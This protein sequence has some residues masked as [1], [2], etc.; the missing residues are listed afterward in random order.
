MNRA[1]IHAIEQDSS[2][3]CGCLKLKRLSR[4]GIDA[5]ARFN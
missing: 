5:L 1:N 4:E 2:R 3:V